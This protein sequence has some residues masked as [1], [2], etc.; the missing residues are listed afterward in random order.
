[1]A[2]LIRRIASRQVFPRCAGPKNPHDTVEHVPRITIGSATIAELRRFFLGEKRAK[3]FP[4]RVGDVHVNVRSDLDRAVDLLT[5]AAEFRSQLADLAG[6]IHEMR[7][8]QP[9]A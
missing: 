9:N 7:S 5:D 4:L 6:T 2:G 8:R 3:E 1:M